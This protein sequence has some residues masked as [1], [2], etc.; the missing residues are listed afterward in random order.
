[1]LDK[2]GRSFDGFWRKKGLGTI[3]ILPVKLFH[4]CNPFCMDD[5][6]RKDSTLLPIEGDLQGNLHQI[7]MPWGLRLR[8][9]GP[10]L[11]L[12]SQQRL[13]YP[14]ED[15]PLRSLGDH[16]RKRLV[17]CAAIQLS[18]LFDH[19]YRPPFTVEFPNPALLN[20]HSTEDLGTR[21]TSLKHAVR[22]AALLF[23]PPRPPPSS[24]RGAAVRRLRRF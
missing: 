24:G 5:A 16:L 4:S 13:G 20:T 19:A 11:P 15:R 17:P 23:A 10:A 7:T 21:R 14:I 12:C 1:M 18:Q 2:G 6:M 22:R 8:H 9:E 3:P